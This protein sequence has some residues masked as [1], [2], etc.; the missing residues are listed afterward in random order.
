MMGEMG[1]AAGKGG[2]AP[3]HSGE[4]AATL[5]REMRYLADFQRLIIKLSGRFINANGRTIDA[6]IND[7]L[8]SIGGFAEVDRSYVFQFSPDGS[9]FSNT[10]EWC[11]PGIEPAM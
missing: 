9:R 5:R 2:A 4:P 11:R 6:E 7:A 8:A 10:H 3:G 1:T